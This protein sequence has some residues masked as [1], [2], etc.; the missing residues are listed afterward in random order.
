MAE[1]S[2]RTFPHRHNPDGTFDSICP[3]CFSTVSTRQNE[4][5]LTDDELDHNCVWPITNKDFRSTASS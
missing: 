3:I 2:D 5:E 4:M 1:H